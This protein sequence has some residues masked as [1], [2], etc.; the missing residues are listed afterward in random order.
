[1]IRLVSDKRTL[2][3]RSIDRLRGHSEVA[4]WLSTIPATRV[5]V[6]GRARI[7]VFTDHTVLARR[8]E[9]AT[10][11]GR[12]R[13]AVPKRPVSATIR[14]PVIK[15]ALHNDCEATALSMLLL[16]YGRHVSQ[17]TLQSQLPRS[18]PL[19]PQQAP[20]GSGPVIWGDPSQG[21]V[22]SAAGTGYGVYQRPVAAL[23]RRHGVAVRDLTGAHPQAV[24][25]ALLSGHSV[26]AWVA[27]SGGPYETWRTPSGR[28]VHAN[29][30]EHTVVFTGISGDSLTVNDPCPVSGSPG[31]RPSSSRCGPRSATEPWPR[32]GRLWETPSWCPVSRR[33]PRSIP[34]Q[35]PGGRLTTSAS[36]RSSAATCSHGSA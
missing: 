22:G 20:G 30:G 7:K 36:R 3:S 29:L 2:A 6:H 35:L 16:D 31:P 28:I 34:G 18:G 12:D 4:G 5:E 1:M 17:L 15:Q 19:T 13:V 25:R 23:A 24:Y 14:L 10:A 32:D 33:Y 9:R 11:A 21:F 26:M 27:L 8:V